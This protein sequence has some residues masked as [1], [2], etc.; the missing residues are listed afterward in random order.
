VGYSPTLE[1]AWRTKIH[2]VLRYTKGASPVLLWTIQ[3][4]RRE[5][6]IR[7]GSHTLGVL[8]ILVIFTGLVQGQKQARSGHN[9]VIP[10]T[11]HLQFVSE[12]IREISAIENIR[13]TC[14]K[15]QK[16]GNQNVFIGSI[17][18]STAMQLELRSQ[19]RMLNDMH[20]KGQFDTLIPSLVVFYQD[21]IEL[22]QRLIDI[23]ENFVGGP[24]SGVD[25]D[26]LAAEV[27][28]LRAKL[29]YA[30]QSVFEATPLI[31][32]T[33]ID[34]RPD[35][36][37][38]VSHLII[39]KE[40]RSSLLDRINTDFG[41]S[42]DAKDPNFNVASASVLRDILLKEYKCSDDSWD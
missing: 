16:E 31:F 24:K 6:M 18:C 27:P 40:E 34:M 35:S 17:H 3:N 20:L 12:Y 14:L 22:H 32:A 11:P 7:N 13:T 2:T 42:L 37:N 39:S 28:K 29:E 15:E 9:P 23:S 10:E 19:V 4:T 36:Q 8:C 1:A 26:K 33:L 41:D 30:E 25:Y 5:I 38:H 21:E